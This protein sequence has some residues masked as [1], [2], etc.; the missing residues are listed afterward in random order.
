VRLDT[1]NEKY[2]RNDKLAFKIK[3]LMKER[4]FY[5]K[6]DLVVLLNVLKPY[7]LVEINAALHQLVEDKTEYITDKYGRTGH[8]INVGD[9]YLF[10]PL[11]LN[12]PNSS[13]YERSVPLE[14]KHAKILMKLPKELKINEAVIK[15]KDQPVNVTADL[16][17]KIATNYT[18]ATTKQ[19]VLK[20]EKNWYMFCH[21]ALDFLLKNGFSLAAL[22]P[23]IAEHI[24]DELDLS[25]V[26]LILNNYTEDPRYETDEAFLFIK[27][28]IQRQLITEKKMQGFLWKEKNQQVLLVKTAATAAAAWHVA[29]PEDLKYFQ[30]KLTENKTN[31]LANLNPLIGFMNNFKTEEFVVFKTKNVNNSRDTGAR[32]DQNSNKGKAID[33]LNTIAGT[34]QVPPSKSISQKELCIIQELYLRLFDKERKDKKR[35]FLSPPE[36]VLTGIESYST[37]AKKKKN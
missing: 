14:V 4:F 7:P 17:A 15:I 22:Q 20:G 3:Q 16:Y 24:L 11:E 13:I 34:Y 30:A 19:I 8:L 36:A 10:Q 12:Q 25:E 5:R 2:I 23:L 35:W 29:E 1:Y 6:K 27:R 21:L 33:I 28:Y 37:V 9:L 18:L 32:C 26:Q 31:I